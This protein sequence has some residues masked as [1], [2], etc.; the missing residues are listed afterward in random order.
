MLTEKLV[1]GI[2]FELDE[3]E[4]LFDL[5]REEL[6]ELNR[7]PN[8]IELTAMASV[9]HSFY[10][11]IERIFILIA[12]NIDKNVPYD[13]NWHKTLLSKMTTPNEFRGIVISENTK[14][15]LSEYLAFRHF[16]RHSYSTRLKWEELKKLVLP[17]QENWGKIRS[18]IFSFIRKLESTNSNIG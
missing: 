1:K 3:I 13:I 14:N 18:E 5:Y 6:F 11:G 2:K 16:Y 8:L 9:L 17:I 7:E 15:E 10:C 12:K 4:N